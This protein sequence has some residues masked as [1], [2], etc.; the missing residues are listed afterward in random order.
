[1]EAKLTIQER[2]KDLRVEHNL[3]LSELAEKTGISTSSLGKYEN[4][5]FKDISPFNLTTLAKYYGVSVDYL[6]GLTEQKKRPETEVEELHISDEMITLLKSGAINNRLLCEIAV[7]KEFARLLADIEIFADRVVSARIRDLNA[8]V[9]A[10]R[11]KITQ[12][13]NPEENEL[14]Y[15]TLE[16]AQIDE[17]IYLENI[18]HRDL[19]AI[20]EDI[21]E[22]HKMDIGAQ[23]ETTIA[24]DFLNYTDEISRIKGS[25]E[26]KLARTYLG[27]LGIK[28]DALSEEEFF[29]LIQILKKSSLLKPSGNRR[30]KKRRK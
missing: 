22:N 20:I 27:A 28:Y 30:G 26:E 13:F 24:E 15:R 5:E 23:P 16:V 19:D 6:L 2:I 4:E 10:A 8:M 11:K 9:V 29:Y 17:K 3:T 14:T 18:I 25:Q 21:Q 1:M 7:H 12:E